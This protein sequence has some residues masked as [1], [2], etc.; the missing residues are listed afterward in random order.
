MQKTGIMDGPRR[1]GILGVNSNRVTLGCAFIYVNI[2]MK[3]LLGFT[4]ILHNG[5]RWSRTYTTETAN[6]TVVSPVLV[7]YQKD[8]Y[9]ERLGLFSTLVF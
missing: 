3:D 8:R 7:E 1:P 4:S 5:R 2:S 6:Q 9:D